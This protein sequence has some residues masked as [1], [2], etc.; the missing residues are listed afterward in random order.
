M[1]A[2]AVPAPALRWAFRPATP[3]E[4]AEHRARAWAAECRAKVDPAESRAAVLSGC[5][6]LQ[7]ALP[8]GLPAVFAVSSPSRFLCVG[9][10]QPASGLHVP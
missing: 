1:S 3:A 6:A 5:Q 2:K 10:S 8:A 7:A 9:P 4:S